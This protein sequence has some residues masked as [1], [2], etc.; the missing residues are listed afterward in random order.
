MITSILMKNVASYKEEVVL[1]T[2][3]KANLIYGLN[4]TGK[5]TLSDF[6][7]NKYDTKFSEC[8][9]NGLN[10]DDKLLVYNQQFIHDNFYETED[11]QGIFTLS[12]ENKQ[13]KEV[14]D[15]AKIKIK[16][17]L[18]QNK[19]Y[20]EEKAVIKKK[21]E[22]NI[23]SCQ[24]KIWEIKTNYA[25]T[26]ESLAYCL[27]GLKGSREALFNYISSI[28]KADEEVEYTIEDLRKEAS[29]LQGSA[30]KMDY[31]KNV[32]IDYSI[33]ETSPL[34]KKII[35]GNKDSAVAEVIDRLENSKWVEEGLQYIHI[36]DGDKICPFCQEKTITTKW[37]ESV[38]SYFDKSYKED[39]V[40]LEKLLERYQEYKIDIPSLEYFG[41]GIIVDK[42]IKDI[43][44]VLKDI[45]TV[46][47]EN[48]RKLEAK[49][50]T[51]NVA[52]ELETTETKFS[53]LNDIIILIN[54]EIKQ[55]NEKIENRQKSLNV[56]KKKF[57]DLM[58]AKYDVVIE[59]YETSDKELKL[60]EKDIQD[61]IN[62]NSKSITLQKQVISENQK[63]TINIDTAVEYIN[64]G[65]L[66]MGISEFSVEKYSEADALYRLKRGESNT[67]VFRSLSEGEKMVIS[68]LYFIE[69]CKGE[70]KVEESSSN[71]IIVIDDPISSLSHI[72]VFNIGRLIHNEFLR[73]EKYEQV[74][75]LTHSLYF[76]YE[77]TCMKKE[78]RDI[79]QKLFRLEKNETGSHFSN[80]KYEEIQ[81]D[82][83]AYWSVINDK[84]QP[85]ALIANCMRNVIE[86]FFNFVEKQD[87]QN[88]FQKKKLQ[89]ARFDAFNRYMNRESHSKGQNI[90]DIKEF[91]YEQ[92][93]KALEL[94]FEETGYKE[95]YKKM[96]KIHS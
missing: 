2:D 19:K 70:K 24:K 10:E 68:F 37:V 96:S 60:Q 80:M 27:D 18:E 44:I 30:D 71:K 89:E 79:M 29:M 16:E 72:Y 55:Y 73:T 20:E 48:I 23:D 87:Y 86:Y 32:E 57:W 63:K 52:V 1:E 83:Q 3:K 45:E 31:I 65:L 53:E 59:M 43:G 82:Y 66:D 56:I 4:G 76:F 78:D 9:I 41:N 42:Y 5:S 17:L 81:N 85:P 92:F 38:K 49:I 14:I 15:D 61:K 22:A 77:L 28:A 51:P 90:F 75:V 21:K 47:I 94:V 33:I 39:K 7:Y 88:V 40:Q 46:I 26:D 84:E 8:R 35:V 95:H 74:F 62:K 67:N 12:K 36:K 93:H 50:Q 11:I 54:E 69:C 6:L 34:L 91:D 13:V 64:Q 25:K 58:R